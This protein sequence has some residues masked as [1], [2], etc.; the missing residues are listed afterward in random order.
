[1]PSG[2]DRLL[3]TS[4][5]QVQS[6][7][8][9]ETRHCAFV[10]FA[11]RGA[12]EKA[13]DALAGR[14]YIHGQR[15][16]LLW[17]KP[18]A[19]RPGAAA[20]ATPAMLPSQVQVHRE[21]GAAPTPAGAEPA[22]AG[23][24]PPPAAGASAAAPAN[25][26]ALPNNGM[27]MQPGAPLYPSMDPQAMGTR[28]QPAFGKRPASGGLEGGAD[29]GAHKQQ[30]MGPPHGYGPP[31]GGG[32]PPMQRPPAG[33]GP[34]PGFP[35]MRPPPMFNSQWGP[36]GPPPMM[37]GPPPMGGPRPPPNAAPPMGPPPAAAT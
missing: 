8:K 28:G 32:Y 6:V 22:A 18:Q 24:A 30:R 26:F 7:R 12:A 36:R 37:G 1:V 33:Y 4:H 15:C 19:P 5:K 2:A 9:L 25:F 31:P 27:P 23:G 10:T 13:A 29:G 21:P 3:S 16:R 34:P 17:G 35:H 11:D 14:L 20:G